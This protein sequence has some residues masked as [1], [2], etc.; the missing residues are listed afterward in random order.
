[1]ALPLPGTV[2]SDVGIGEHVQFA[3]APYPFPQFDLRFSS[4]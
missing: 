3:A 1:M 2:L 4:R